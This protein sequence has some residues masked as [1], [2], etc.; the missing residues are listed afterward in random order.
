MRKLTVITKYITQPQ[1]VLLCL[2]L[3][4][5]LILVLMCHANWLLLKQ[6]VGGQVNVSMVVTIALK[7]VIRVS[8]LKSGKLL[9]ARQFGLKAWPI[10][11]PKSK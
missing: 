2:A 10:K 4:I 6:N 3:R 7:H 8:S 5:K 11:V 9:D 1:A